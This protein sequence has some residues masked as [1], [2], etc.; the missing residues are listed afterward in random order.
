[1]TAALE[2]AAARSEEGRVS[3]PEATA[4]LLVDV[5]ESLDHAL[6][7]PHS[8]IQG[9]MRGLMD[10]PREG[11]LVVVMSA[12]R[13]TP[14]AERVGHYVE[15]WAE[16]GSPDADALTRGHTIRRLDGAEVRW[17]N[18]RIVRVSGI[19]GAACDAL[20]ARRSPAPTEPSST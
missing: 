3:D 15:S 14:A 9:A 19:Y 2:R 10:Q 7:A 5:A 12:R 6:T 18:A 11:D 20:D 13:D 1:M 17:T 8:P 16:L 4:A